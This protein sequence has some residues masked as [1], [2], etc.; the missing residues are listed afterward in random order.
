M[1]PC[2][3]IL[4]IRQSGGDGVP[5]SDFRAEEMSTTHSSAPLTEPTRC[6][7]S[8]NFRV[9]QLALVRALAE[10]RASQFGLTETQLDDLVLAVHEIAAN[11]V[12][13]RGG[14]G[15]FRLWRDGPLA[16][17]RDQRP[18]K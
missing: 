7:E 16:R 4:S 15:R 3:L 1:R 8:M 2:A 5:S 18:G 6:L 14:E 13:H 10:A 9:G 11:S 17:G 12:R